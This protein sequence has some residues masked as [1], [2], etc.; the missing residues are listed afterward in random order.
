MRCNAGG[1]GFVGG[2][3]CVAT[4][5]RMEGM[6]SGCRLGLGGWGGL[7]ATWRPRG[8]IWS[9]AMGEEGAGLRSSPCGLE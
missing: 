6:F 9:A 5:G 7:A 3:F 2:G 1:R 8:P 4:A